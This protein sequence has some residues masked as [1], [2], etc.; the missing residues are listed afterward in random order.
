L[1]FNK[2]IAK[3][4]KFC[5]ALIKSYF[6][7]IRENNKN[8][9]FI[10]LWVSLL[11]PILILA[12]LVYGTDA[13]ST[14]QQTSKSSTEVKSIARFDTAK[15]EVEFTPKVLALEKYTDP[16]ICQWKNDAKAALSFS[17]DD[18]TVD[19]FTLAAPMLE[20]YGL[21]GTFFIVVNWIGKGNRLTWDHVKS[22][23]ERGHEIGSHTMT[24]GNMVSLFKN[25]DLAN[26]E[27]EIVDPIGIIKEKIGV[28]PVTFAFPLGAR[29]PQVQAMVEQ[30]FLAARG[31]DMGY[32]GT[33][34]NL[35]KTNLKIDAL[36]AKGE[37]G[38]VL[39]H[40]IDPAVKGY[41]PFNDPTLLDQHFAYVKS[42]E[43]ELWVDTYANVSRYQ[44][45]VAACKV[46]SIRNT[47]K[48]MKF[49]LV[50]NEPNKPE[51]NVPLTIRID[52]SGAFEAS[53]GGRKLLL[54]SQENATLCHDVYPNGGVVKVQFAPL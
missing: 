30:H 47:Q 37:N 15:Q 8:I 25:G 39:I 45:T 23:E 52:R 53:Q 6:M 20:K 2:S 34:F 51:K 46:K 48:L 35:E 29:N 26:L 44:F 42:R 19:H 12:N 3:F 7:N 16:V 41:K 50:S 14:E 49:E 21:R 10:K 33:I 22:L 4:V 11:I 5:F 36:I 13:L 1:Y 18:A 28:P 27:K 24:H 43:K 17:F 32:D 9:K 54:S 38:V 40:G 31:R